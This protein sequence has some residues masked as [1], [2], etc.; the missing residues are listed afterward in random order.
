MLTLISVVEGTSTKKPDS[1]KANCYLVKMK[2]KP[3]RLLM[4]LLR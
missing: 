4:E 2:N 3:A 1:T